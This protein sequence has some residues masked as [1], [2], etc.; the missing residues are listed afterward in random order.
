[1][2]KS[3]QDQIIKEYLKFNSSASRRFLEKQFPWFRSYLIKYY[4]NSFKN[5]CKNNSITFPNKHYVT[6]RKLSHTNVKFLTFLL[7]QRVANKSQLNFFLSNSESLRAT[8]EKLLMLKKFDY[9]AVTK[10]YKHNIWQITDKGK[11]VLLKHVEN[12]SDYRH[13]KDIKP[14]SDDIDH[15]LLVNDVRLVLTRYFGQRLIRWYSDSL[16][17]RYDIYHGDEKLKGLSKVQNKT[18]GITK[19]HYPDGMIEYYD[20]NGVKRFAFIE[21]ERTHK[22]TNIYT[23]IFEQNVSEYYELYVPEVIEDDRVVYEAKRL[24]PVDYYYYILG[25]HS[26]AL[27]MTLAG[28]RNVARRIL[29]AENWYYNMNPR[30]LMESVEA[31]N[32]AE[33]YQD[34]MTEMYPNKTFDLDTSED[35]ANVLSKL[36]YAVLRDDFDISKIEIFVWD[37]IRRPRNESRTYRESD[38]YKKL[39]DK[40]DPVFSFLDTFSCDP[41]G[42]RCSLD[43]IGEYKAPKRR[44]D[45]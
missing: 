20:M 2:K 11:S 1:M 44:G 23:Q 22:N 21:M 29:D 33:R 5:L 26:C 19:F 7:E 9:I 13:F 12:V 41:K 8:Y 45:G 34:A 4:K 17:R 14:G 24:A 40:Y 37:K 10:G 28:R 35:Y 30:N 38:V 25:P 36:P 31:L 15:D 43:W 27:P 3:K 18:T 39:V 32:I 6:I 42:E 16:L